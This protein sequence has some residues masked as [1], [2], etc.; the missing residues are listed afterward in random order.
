MLYEVITKIT[1]FFT[2]GQVIT[3]ASYTDRLPSKF[4]L[5][6]IEATIASVTDPETEALL[7]QKYPSLVSLSRELGEK[8]MVSISNEFD[9]WV[10]FNPEERY[11]LLLKN[12]PEL[13]QRIPQY[14]L[15]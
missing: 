12:R 3:P 7:Y 15:A 8:L 5:S 9:D 4:Y 10:R 1:G 11:L 2:E 13:L 14:Q 6:C